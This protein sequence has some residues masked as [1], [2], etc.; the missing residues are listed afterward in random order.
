MHLLDGDGPNAGQLEPGGVDHHGGVH[1]LEGTCLGQGHLAA[2]AFLGRG[3]QDQD[4]TPD[5]VGHLRCRQTSA[6]AGRADHVVTARMPDAGKSVV[7]AKHRHQRAR[8]AGT[9]REGGW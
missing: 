4:A 8:I 9:G 6:D 3:P 2:T 5:L 1:S 7:L